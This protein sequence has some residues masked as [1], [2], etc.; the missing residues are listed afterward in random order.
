V[1][2]AS[3]NW[4]GAGVAVHAI[5]VELDLAIPAGDD[6]EPLGV[7]ANPE[8]IGLG[9]CPDLLNGALRLRELSSACSRDRPV[10][11]HV[12]AALGEERANSVWPTFAAAQ[13]LKQSGQLSEIRPPRECLSGGSKRCETRRRCCILRGERLLEIGRR[14]GAILPRLLGPRELE[15][16]H[17]LDEALRG[18]QCERGRDRIVAA[19]RGFKCGVPG[20]GLGGAESFGQLNRRGGVAGGADFPGVVCNPASRFTSRSPS[21]EDKFVRFGQFGRTFSTKVSTKP[22][23]LGLSRRPINTQPAE[24]QASH[25]LP[26]AERDPCSIRLC[27]NR[28]LP[29]AR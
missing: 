6:G 23:R 4:P 2:T 1:Y 17:S 8:S 19:A 28:T 22:G 3:A 15:A 11:T 25:A 12:R 20:R 5:A 18:M 13:A 9:H 24:M 14:P 26:G 7:S 27:T 21:F 16:A 29:V 10:A